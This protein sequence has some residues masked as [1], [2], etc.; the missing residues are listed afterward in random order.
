MRRKKASVSE[1]ISHSAASSQNRMISDQ[2]SENLEV[3]HSMFTLTPD[4][5]IR[6]FQS[7]S[8]KG[9]VAIVYLEGMVDKNSI[10]NNVLRP[11]LN[12]TESD[13][14]GIFDL[15]SVGKISNVSDFYTVNEKILLG[16]SVIFVE[17]RHEAYVLDTNG[18]PQRAIEDPKLEASLKGG[19]QAF[20]ETGIQNIAL[21]RRYI[22]NR[23]LKIK[24]FWVGERGTCK[25]SVMFIS[26]IVQPDMLQ[27]LENRINKLNVDSFLNIGELEEMIEDNPFS[28]FPQFLST[29]RPDSTASHLLQGRFVI[30]LDRSPNVLIGPI[31]FI[32][33]FHSV[34]DYSTRWLVASFIR[35]LRCLALLVATFLPALY[36][37]LISYNYELIPLDL[38]LTVG[39]SRERVPFPPL[40]EAMIMELTLE[41]LREAGI[42]LP[43]PIG[44]TVGIVGG[45]VIGQ[46]VVQAGIV[47]NVMVIVVAFT[48][49][50]SFIFPNYDMAAAVRLLRFA[51]MVLAAMFGIVG[52]VIGMMALIGHLISLES[53]GAPYA[54]PLAP[55]RFRDW[56]DLFVR[57]PLWLMKDR[58][59]SAMPTQSR[60][61]G[62]NRSEGDQ[63]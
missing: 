61:Q 34:D 6:T 29:E 20:I 32:S 50:S 42:R 44:Q 9:K 1:R 48:A 37:A 19:R 7:H 46:A 18:W 51:M 39:E 30:I 17:G 52:I 27:V 10:N 53:L 25:I 33:F 26:D 36:I 4:L 13:G 24:E 31:T 2:L 43:S 47:S 59:T 8:M 62:N 55:V 12:T 40:I 49:I 3:L 11:L 23:E 35:L 45:I 22:P 15:L 5:V 38:I 54:N 28:P 57:L 58:P 60:R 63:S 16:S 41:M 14:A 56:K 21:I